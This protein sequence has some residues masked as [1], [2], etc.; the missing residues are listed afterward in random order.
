MAL[1]L[2]LPFHPFPLP[3][4]PLH[5]PH[6]LYHHQHYYRQ[7]IH[8]EKYLR[9]PLPIRPLHYP[10][11]LYHHFSLPFRPL[12]YPH[13]R[14]PFLAQYNYKMKYQYL[15]IVKYLVKMECILLF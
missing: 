2:L 5:Y 4:R 15:K 11:Y 9:N 13:Y 3:F 8:L 7:I 10:H 14:L 6:Y 12:H 1:H